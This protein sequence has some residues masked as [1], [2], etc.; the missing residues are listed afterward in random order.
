MAD[1]LSGIGFLEDIDAI[2]IFL[3]V[4]AVIYGLLQ[5]TKFVGTNKS[6]HAFVAFLVAIIFLLSNF[7]NEV[8]KM[9]TPWFVILFM[10]ILFLLTSI[11]MFGATDTDI[12]SVM[13]SHT[14]II[15]W[16]IALSA[17]IVIGSISTVFS[18][19]GDVF[20]EEGDAGPVEGSSSRVGSSATAGE[21]GFWGTL[22]HP[23]VLGLAV[24]F[25]ISS[26]TIR[27]MMQS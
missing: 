11:K 20:G 18:E 9:V 24:I 25:L 10:F 6:I 21:S 1:L 13:K 2:F 26:F 23:K 27:Y 5:Y 16:L 19:Q 17:I 3:L 4:L 7:A 14:N 12:L 8:I 15:W 22:S